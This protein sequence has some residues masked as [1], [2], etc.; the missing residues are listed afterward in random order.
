MPHDDETPALP[1]A[2]GLL[3]ATLALMTAHARPARTARVDA[4]VQ[5]RL[6]ARKIVSNLF[7]LREHP[8][9]SPPLRQVLATLHTLWA[10]I[11]AEEA[12]PRTTA[13]AASP[14]GAAVDAPGAA[15]VLH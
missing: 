14:A 11:A 5:R 8:A 10:G 4:D 7:F 12:V 3:A 9:V 1:C 15:A 6:L 13:A 2:E